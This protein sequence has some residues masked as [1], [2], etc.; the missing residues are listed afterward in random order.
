[1]EEVQES[2][3]PRVSALIVSRNCVDSLRKSLAALDASVPRETLEIVVADNGSR[4]GSAQLDAEFPSAHFLRMPKNFGRTKAI[5]I[6]CR[7]AKGELLLL[8]SPGVEVRPDTVQRLADRLE[9]EPDIG[10]VTPYTP[11]AYPLPDAALLK[12][13]ISSGAL[14]GGRSVDRS[15]GQVAVDYPAGAPLLLR[16]GFLQ[17]MRYLDERFGQYW[18]DA[19]L[20]YQI[21]SAGKKILVV[22]DVEV[23]HSRPESRPSGDAV[24]AADWA[25]GAAAYAGKHFGF[26]SGLGI[27]LGSA[28]GALGRAIVFS[29]PGYNFKRF[30]AL[31]GGQKVDGTQE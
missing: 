22:T 20:C 7:T 2:V 8:L 6:G 12:Q 26:M 17:G 4:D 30:T 18:W 23:D 25:G 14:P 11:I 19:E 3:A 16:R 10:A 9:S 1:M 21:R 24:D 31:L 5:N 29:S 28:F 27:R 13:A 15:L